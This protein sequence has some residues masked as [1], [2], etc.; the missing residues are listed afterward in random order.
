[1]TRA[2]PLGQVEGP[3][4]EFKSSESRPIDIAR[5]VVAL[6]N[7]AGGEIWWGIKAENET[8]VAEDPFSDG[9]ARRRDLQNHLIDTIEP[10]PRIP[11]EVALELVSARGAGQIMRIEVTRLGQ[12]RAPA[13]Q[14][15]DQGR[16]FWIRVGDRVRIMTR[17]EVATK[18]KTEENPDSSLEKR[19]LV[20]REAVQGS[21]KPSFWMMI[22]PHPELSHQDLKL[23]DPAL[24]ELLTNP[25]ATGNRRSGWNFVVELE[26]P[27]VE[28]RG[29]G[30]GYDD[31]EYVLIRR[32]GAIVSRVPLER[33]HWKGGD[34]EIWPYALLEFPVSLMRLAATFFQRWGP[35]VDYVLVDFAFVGLAGWTLRG[36]SPRSPAGRF[37]APAPFK[38]RDLVPPRP[39]RF[40][41]SELLEEPD[42]CGLRVITFVY[43][44]FGY[45][46]QSIPPEFDRISGKLA[47]PSG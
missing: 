20:D 46:E 4:L 34:H 32:D 28:R 29:L 8:A 2:I 39:F 10:S 16:R 33:L 3:K 7:A 19:L 38:D 47:F 26:Q 30:H 6:L 9:E 22:Q 45:F 23:A 15:K 31:D 24:K 43:E 27:K 37:G 35:N 21:K 5:E 12:G 40:D 41:R 11:D 1:M 17:D 14:I 36:G 42:R 13:A 25:L 44:A 18:F